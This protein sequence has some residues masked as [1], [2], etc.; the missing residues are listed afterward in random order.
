MRSHLSIVTNKGSHG[1][2][3]IALTMLHVCII[4]TLPPKEKEEEEEYEDMTIYIIPSTILHTHTHIA[5][6]IR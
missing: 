1:N 6:C 5:L 3:F 2:C 4:Q